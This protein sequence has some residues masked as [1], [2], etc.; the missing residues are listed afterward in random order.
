M[1]SFGARLGLLRLHD[2]RLRALSLV[3]LN[4]CKL[5][6]LVELGWRSFE[7]LHI[8]GR[9]RALSLVRL[10]QWKLLSLVQ[11]RCISSRARA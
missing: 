7:G 8:E 11:L 1:M 6:S 4:E 10:H 3:R 9:L 2:W 5:L